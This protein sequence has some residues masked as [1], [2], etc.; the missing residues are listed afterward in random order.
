MSLL[1]G[2]ARRKVVGSFPLGHYS[3][4]KRPVNWVRNKAWYPSRKNSQSRAESYCIWL[5]FLIIGLIKMR[6]PKPYY[7]Y[8]YCRMTFLQILASTFP[9]KAARNMSILKLY[10]CLFAWSEF[11]RLRPNNTSMKIIV[12]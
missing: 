6:Q 2:A 9:S 5:T 11:R 4:H 3:P 1:V 7:Y 10:R 12:I 8:Y